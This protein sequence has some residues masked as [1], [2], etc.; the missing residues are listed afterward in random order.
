MDDK[1]GKK[2]LAPPSKSAAESAQKLAKR[3][4]K[5]AMARDMN[6]LSLFSCQTIKKSLA[7]TLVVTC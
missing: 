5:N 3:N 2:A 4:K 1:E 7:V 6:T